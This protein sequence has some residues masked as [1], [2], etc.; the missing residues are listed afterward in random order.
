MVLLGYKTDQMKEERLS[1]L[2][3]K[4]YPDENIEVFDNSYDQ[5][6]W[7]QKRL[8]E[9][10]KPI[11]KRKKKKMIKLLNKIKEVLKENDS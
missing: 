10:E 3:K 4:K 9:L 7:F 11:T 5:V 6:E 2:F 8:N 1:Y